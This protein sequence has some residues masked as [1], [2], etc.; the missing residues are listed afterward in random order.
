LSGNHR[1]A[2]LLRAGMLTVSFTTGSFRF[3]RP[4]FPRAWPGIRK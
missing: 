2:N 3:S 4:G 1:I